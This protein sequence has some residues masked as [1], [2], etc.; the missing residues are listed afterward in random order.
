MRGILNDYTKSDMVSFNG[1][2]ST[3]RKQYT[4]R[5]QPAMNLVSLRTRKQ[6]VLLEYTVMDP[7]AENEVLATDNRKNI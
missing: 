6:A 3:Q 7:V 2:N 5:P 4:P 1:I